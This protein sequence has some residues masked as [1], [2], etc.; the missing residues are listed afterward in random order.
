MNG[1]KGRTRYMKK[2]DK[3]INLETDIKG[4]LTLFDKKGWLNPTGEF[5]L[6]LK[7]GKFTDPTATQK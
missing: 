5:D 6:A 2:T 1:R 3:D 7:N 4:V